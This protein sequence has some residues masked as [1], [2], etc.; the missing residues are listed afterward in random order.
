[1]NTNVAWVLL[2]LLLGACGSSSVKLG[3]TAEPVDTSDPS[4]TANTADLSMAGNYTGVLSSILGT[5]ANNEDWI[6]RRCEGPVTL[7]VTDAGELVGTAACVDTSS[8][9]GV[10]IGGTLSGTVSEGAVNGTWAYLFWGEYT[11]EATLTATLT[12]SGLSGALADTEGSWWALS[13]GTVVA[14]R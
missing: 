3:D 1:M 6:E 10:E 9:D 12:E 14:E 2:A 11:G 4:D 8:P 5:G 13:E 7:E